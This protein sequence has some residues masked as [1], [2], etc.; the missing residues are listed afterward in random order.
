MMKREATGRSFDVRLCWS[1]ASFVVPTLWVCGWCLGGGWMVSVCPGDNG[2]T[3]HMQLGQRQHCV[4]GR[5]M[6]NARCPIR[7]HAIQLKPPTH[8]TRTGPG[9]HDQEDKALGHPPSIEGGSHLPRRPAKKQ[10]A[11]IRVLP[12]G[13]PPAPASSH[14]APDGRFH[15]AGHFLLP[16]GTYVGFFSMA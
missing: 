4:S 2:N 15:W 16:P 14:L 8:S 9:H 7:C 6:I 11:R 5:S 12:R 13:A 3:H 10:N 1:A